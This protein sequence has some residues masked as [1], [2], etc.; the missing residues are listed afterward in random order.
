MASR[1]HDNRQSA[2]ST[3]GQKNKPRWGE[4]VERFTVDVRESSNL[5]PRYKIHGGILA[6]IR[7]LP[8]CLSPH[9]RITMYGKYPVC[10]PRYI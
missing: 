1:A 4:D 9:E 3:V 10:A 6:M 8:R 5:G 2:R 7:Q